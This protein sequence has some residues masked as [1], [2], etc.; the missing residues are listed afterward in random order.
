LKFENCIISFI[1]I[2]HLERKGKL[3]FDKS[4]SCPNETGENPTTFKTHVF[5][6]TFENKMFA[7]IRRYEKDSLKLNLMCHT[8]E[9]P[10]GEVSLSFAYMALLKF[11]H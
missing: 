11:F 9:T 4:L 10:P 1:S 7:R 6:G 2:Q 8:R 3:S 5:R